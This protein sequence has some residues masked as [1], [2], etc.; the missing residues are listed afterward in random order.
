MIDDFVIIDDDESC[1]N[2]IDLLDLKKGMN[3]ETIFYYDK[4]IDNIFKSYKYNYNRIIEQFNKD[5]NRIKIYVDDVQITNIKYFL[6]NYKLKLFDIMLC[7]QSSF[8]WPYEKIIDFHNIKNDHFLIDCNN[9]YLCI[10]I[11]NNHININ[12]KLKIIKLDNTK[13]ILNNVEFL[14]NVNIFLS[15]PLNK[16]YNSLYNYIYNKNYTTMRWEIC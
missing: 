16:T 12:K 4:Y 2:K 9:S 5:F 13:S 11:K 10:N 8:G 14:F 6:N 3:F 15:L 1:N 7:T